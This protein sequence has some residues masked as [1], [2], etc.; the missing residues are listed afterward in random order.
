PDGE[1]AAP[2]APLDLR[3]RPPHQRGRVG[4]KQVLDEHEELVHQGPA[5]AHPEKRRQEQ[6]RREQ[7]EHEVVGQGGGPIEDLI[8]PDLREGE[9]G[10][11]PDREPA[12]RPRRDLAPAAAPPLSET[13]EWTA[14][15][16]GHRHL[17]GC[18]R[19]HQAI[20][21]VGCAWA[22]S[23]GLS[24]WGGERCAAEAGWKADGRL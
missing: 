19:W 9:P 11:L 13:P 14:R 23:P 18:S 10:E 8:L 5:G 15:L 1:E 24:R 7:R 16:L 21:V 4:R 12:E 3:E 17:G 22:S 6:E 2:R 20:S